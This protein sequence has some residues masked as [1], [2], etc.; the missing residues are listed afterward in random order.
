MLCNPAVSVEVVKD[1]VPPETVPV[2][3]VDP[4][5][6]NVAVPVVDPL[7]GAVT[8]TFA[9]KVTDCPKVDESAVEGARTYAVSTLPLT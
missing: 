6:L 1:A 4:P 7:P 5:S 9:V 2:P 8:S 3:I